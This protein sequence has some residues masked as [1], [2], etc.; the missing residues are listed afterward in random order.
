MILK[1]GSLS[2][3]YS[4]ARQLLKKLAYF[5]VHAS[6]YISSVQMQKSNQVNQETTHKG[7]VCVALLILFFLVHF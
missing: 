5:W 3:K 4:Y 2:L 7:P 6:I 1:E